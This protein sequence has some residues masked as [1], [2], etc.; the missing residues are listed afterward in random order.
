VTLEHAIEPLGPPARPGLDLSLPPNMPKARFAGIYSELELHR[1]A[2]AAYTKPLFFWRK[3][4]VRSHDGRTLYDFARHTSSNL[5]KLHGALRTG[6]FRFRE[7]VEVTWNFNGKVRTIQ[8]FP[9]EER[10]VD[11]L[12]YR[13]LSSRFQSAF[14]HHSYAYRVRG[15]GLD[16]CQRRIARG[17]AA[18][19]RP[20]WCVKRDV[21]NFF[22]SIDHERLLAILAEWIDPADYLFE[23][24]RQRVQFQTRTN[25]ELRT[26][27]LGVPFGTAIACFLANLYLTPLDRALETIPGLAYFRY[28]D[29]V[30][31]FT[32]DR[33][34]AEQ[35]SARYEDVL[36]DLRLKGNLARSIDLRL[37]P[38]AAGAGAFAGGWR[39]RH[40]GIEFRE[41][42]SIGLSRDKERKIRNLFR[43]AFRR[44]RRKFRMAG[45]AEGRA[46]LAVD[47][48]R[49]VVEN[50]L[51]SVAIVD[52][53]LKHV[54]DEAQLRLID[55][56]LAEEVLFRA[57]G[58]GHRKGNFRKMSFARLREMGLPSLVYR[59]RLLQHG[60]LV[61]SFFRMR[62]E[63]LIER[64]G[65]RLPGRKAFPPDPEAAA[66]KTPRG[67]GGRL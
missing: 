8:I 47:I 59:R 41:N 54:N 52:Y 50:G 4:L 61:S 58:G 48:A 42:G 45:S 34:S 16:L 64:E 2:L 46:R 66:G 19:P 17:L 28:A 30:L 36:R 37:A 6:A 22:P 57:F 14:S 1:A 11:H 55:R 27:T 24:L 3:A 7:A 62:T 65:R 23:L 51:R 5:Q 31:A 20:V 43:F 63:R 49:R 21:A 9:W 26:A 13:T 38:D 39:F 10:I 12:L 15:Y 33:A 60:R 32:A 40:L 35:A 44:A 53:Y 25:G 56:W 67:E 29:D 18:L